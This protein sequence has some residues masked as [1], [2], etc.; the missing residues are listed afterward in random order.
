ML[1]SESR[2]IEQ[3]LTKCIKRKRQY[4]E[5]AG[6]HNKKAAEELKAAR[7]KEKMAL[8]EM[9]IEYKLRESLKDILKLTGR[10]S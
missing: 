10:S 5:Q 7:T 4:D 8:G 3:N 2:D 6:Y 1:L 9:E